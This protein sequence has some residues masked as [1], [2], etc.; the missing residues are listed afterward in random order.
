MSESATREVD[1]MSEIT[2][3]ISRMT[4]QE[5]GRK[6]SM[7]IFPDALEQV[8]DIAIEH[9]LRQTALE[10]VTPKL[11]KDWLE[12]RKVVSQLETVIYEKSY[13]FV[14]ALG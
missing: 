9:K 11:I 4:T 5:K 13:C 10:E 12:Q 3:L 14:K 7:G 8:Y 1:A 2:A 6:V